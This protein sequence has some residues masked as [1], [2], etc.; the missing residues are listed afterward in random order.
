M[1]P[2]IALKR[3]L[4]SC[5]LRS[6]ALSWHGRRHGRRQAIL[7]VY[8]RVNDDGDPF[9]PALSRRAFAEQLDHLHANYR[10]DPLED[11]A[12]WLAS[13]A[14][15]RARASIT[16]DDGYPDTLE[17]ALPELR[18][19]GLPATLFL[20][21]APPETGEPLWTDRVRWTVKSAR[22]REVALPSIGWPAQTLE[23]TAGKIAFLARLLPALKARGPAEVDAAVEEL[24]AR[25]DPAGPP[26]GLLSWDDVRRLAGN[27]IA[28]GGHTHRHYMLSRLHD[29]VLRDEI[30]L[31]IRLIE[32]RVGIRVRSFAYPNGEPADYDA[33]ALAILRELGLRCAVTCRHA[34]AQPD[35]DPLQLPRLYST[36]PSLAV[37]A[38]RVAGLGRS[39]ASEVSAC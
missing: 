7:L 6:G 24:G 20:A 35:H 12:A 32:D 30:A 28:L 3:V 36:E 18:R 14:D 19:R 37:F 11:V 34:P 38:A 10:V 8:H 33:R 22:A 9:F 26:L 31:S 27:G 2:A 13:G 5:L 25:L 29:D 39:E 16:I 23:D 17:V 1:T 15:G 21:T 4:A